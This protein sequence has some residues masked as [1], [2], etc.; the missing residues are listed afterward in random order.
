M[1]AFTHNKESRLLK[2]KEAAVLLLNTGNAHAFIMANKDFIPRVIP[3][4]F[5][6][7]FD[8]IMA[9]GHAIEDVKA[10]TNKMLNI[11]H[12]PITAYKRP[13]P[14]PASF[15][16][17]LEQNNQ[18]MEQLLHAIRPVFKAF[19]QDEENTMLMDELAGLFRR[20][21]QFSNQYTIKENVLFPVIEQAWPDYRCLQIMWSF[22]DDIR[23]NIRIIV[24]QLT[25]RTI[26]IKQ[27][28][29]CVGDVF[30]NM[31]AIKFREEHILFPHILETIDADQLELMTSQGAEIGFPFVQ[32]ALAHTMENTAK[33]SQGMVDLGTGELSID[34]LVGIFNHLPVDI[35]YVDKQ[36]VVR[37]FSTPPKR[38]FPR[39]KAI[40]GRKVSNCHP[41]ESVHIVEQ[42][43]SAFR[44]GEKSQADFWIRMKGEMILIRYFAVRDANGNYKGV[45][46]VSQE[47]SEIQAL[48]GEKRLLD[49]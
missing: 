36:D 1:S 29:R 32:P 14:D 22:H 42:I 6:S 33:A 40:I 24:D 23:R 9:Q 18:Q 3:S 31:L 10:L 17:L 43:I 11:F 21:E 44:S 48:E 15:L 8:D 5:I 27:F 19:V 45:I 46:E 4:D 2:L 26:N 47:V 28:K 37:F 16:G 30:F 20:L 7:L 13:E 38:I 41:H 35:T 49:W 34:Q 25:S 39:T 12:I